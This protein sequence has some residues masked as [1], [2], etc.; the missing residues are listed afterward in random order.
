MNEAGFRGFAEE[1][2]TRI[3]HLGQFDIEL[4]ANGPPVNAYMVSVAGPRKSSF[5]A[6]SYSCMNSLLWPF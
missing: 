6:A 3:P 5:K 4:L 1:V 2:H